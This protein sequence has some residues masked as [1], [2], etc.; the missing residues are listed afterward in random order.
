MHITP[1]VSQS[2][3]GEGIV[4]HVEEAPSR[5][6]SFTNPHT[7]SVHSIGNG[8]ESAQ[9]ERMHERARERA[10]ALEAPHVMRVGEDEAASCAQAAETDSRVNDTVAK[11]EQTLAVQASPPLNVPD[12]GGGRDVEHVTELTKGTDSRDFQENAS[13]GRDANVHGIVIATTPTNSSGASGSMSQTSS[14]SRGEWA[15]RDPAGGG[16]RRGVPDVASVPVHGGGPGVGGAAGHGR[17]S[18]RGWAEELALSPGSPTGFFGE[19]EELIRV[20]SSGHNV[21]GSESLQ[22][23]LACCDSFAPSSDSHGQFSV[24]SAVGGMMGNGQQQV[25]LEYDASIP[26]EV[27]ITEA[28]TKCRRSPTVVSANSQDLNDWGMVGRSTVRDD[29]KGLG[30]VGNSSCYRR[31]RLPPRAPVVCTSHETMETIQTKK[32]YTHTL[33]S[34]A[35]TAVKPIS[36]QMVFC[37]PKKSSITTAQAQ[38]NGDA[39]R[40]GLRAILDFTNRPRD[41]WSSAKSQKILQARWSPFAAFSTHAC[42]H[43]RTRARALSLPHTPALNAFLLAHPPTP[44]PTPPNTPTHTRTRA[45]GP[46]DQAGTAIEVQD[47]QQKKQRLF[48]GSPILVQVVSSAHVPLCVHRRTLVH[49]HTRTYIYTYSHV[50]TRTH[51]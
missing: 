42:T 20:A 18:R 32:N 17:E 28:F 29:Y 4:S 39:E 5:G 8:Q 46:E 22:S 12:G 21:R 33:T 45:L 13:V 47:E 14:H 27:V 43:S 7:V 3:Q 48:A 41:Q 34:E 25:V 16:E 51:T 23:Q 24:R 10:P 6:W 49:R 9:R 2:L 11:S 19:V 31:G 36:V 37:T 40:S 15:A 1:A 30:A 35:G 50:H 44:P 38:T 26:Q